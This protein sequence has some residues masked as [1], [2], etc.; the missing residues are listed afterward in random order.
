MP[1][2]VMTVRVKFGGTTWWGNAYTIGAGATRRAVRLI[3]EVANINATNV[4]FVAGS[5]SLSD[6]GSGSAAGIGSSLPTHGSTFT[7]NG[8]G[9][10]DTTSAQ[11]LLVSVQ[12][13]ASDANLSF[14]K[15][16]ALLELL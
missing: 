4:Q 13:G 5:L 8:N 1:P 16:Y 6:S 15:K 9:N 10:I 14:R 11:T 3:V 2:S 7:S 12:H